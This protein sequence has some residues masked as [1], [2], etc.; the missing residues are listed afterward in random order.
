M[1]GTSEKDIKL[2]W[3]R[4]A[5][6][7]AF[8]DCH[9]KLT[10]DTRAAS[11]A[12]PLGEQ[13][14]I[15]AEKQDGPRGKSLLT[16]PERNS[17]FNL[18]L[19][20]PSHHRVIDKD[21]QGYPI[22]RLHLLKDQHEL[23]VDQTLS[24]RE[25]LRKTAA[26]LTYADLIDCAVAKC[27]FD[28]WDT[29]AGRLMSPHRNCDVELESDIK[30][31]AKKVFRAVWTGTLEEFER[32][33]RTLSSATN[34][35]MDKLGE[36]FAKHI[37]MRDYDGR[38]LYWEVYPG[39]HG[40]IED[41]S[42]YHELLREHETWGDEVDALVVE[43]TKAANWVSDVVRRDINPMFFATSGKLTITYGPLEDLRTRTMIPEYTEEDRKGM[44]YARRRPKAPGQAKNSGRKR[45]KS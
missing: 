22:E 17:Y 26:D 18:I 11:D 44:P 45:Q 21:P 12:F 41:A 32:A 2:L 24:E 36:D 10:Q 30:D 38:T 13:A 42:L 8:P 27:R 19:V 35:L 43:A 25:D 40:W 3:G 29:W 15:V 6:R 5:S 39:H 23:W 28:T 4:A 9:I 37:E 20:C 31:F 34:D 14:H 16:E 7:C 33:I 1:A